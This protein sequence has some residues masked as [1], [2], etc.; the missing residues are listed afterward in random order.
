[1]LFLGNILNHQYY[2]LMQMMSYHQL[3]VISISFNTKSKTAKN[4]L[5]KFGLNIAH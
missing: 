5:N 1:M 2:L 4:K 3:L